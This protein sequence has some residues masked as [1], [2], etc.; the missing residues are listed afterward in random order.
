MWIELKSIVEKV[1]SSDMKVIVL[2]STT[3]KYFTAGLDCE[4]AYPVRQGT[5]SAYLQCSDLD[6]ISDK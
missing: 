6:I 3:D 2:S 1:S 4:H 5:E